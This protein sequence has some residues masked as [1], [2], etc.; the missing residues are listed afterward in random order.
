MKKIIKLGMVSLALLGSVA[1]ADTTPLALHIDPQ[2]KLSFVLFHNA[3]NGE[4]M[5]CSVDKQGNLESVQDCHP[6]KLTHDWELSIYKDAAGGNVAQVCR[7]H[8]GT[9]ST[10]AELS[11][12]ITKCKNDATQ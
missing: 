10:T 9:L 2:L 11:E 6:E 5:F 4:I 8:I 1:M 7:Q 12:V 3:S